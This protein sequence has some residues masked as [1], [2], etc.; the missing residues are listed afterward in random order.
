[1]QTTL[2]LLL[3]VAALGVR[4]WAGYAY[5]KFLDEQPQA[6]REALR[7]AMARSGY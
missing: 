6:V 3:G 5:A 1:M 4:V 7:R 2:L